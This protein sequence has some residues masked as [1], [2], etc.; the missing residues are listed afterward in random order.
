[1]TWHTHKGWPKHSTKL[2]A[3]VPKKPKKAKAT[4]PKK[5]NK[6]RVT[7]VHVARTIGRG[8]F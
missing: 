7:H 3:S 4:H 1:M 5:A 6:A 8:R 2:K